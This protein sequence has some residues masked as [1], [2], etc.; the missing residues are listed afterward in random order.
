MSS[1][2]EMDLND[3]AVQAVKHHRDP[4][5]AKERRDDFVPIHVLLNQLLA[6]VEGDADRSAPEG[7]QSYT[8]KEADCVSV[9]WGHAIVKAARV[10]NAFRDA[11]ACAGGKAPHERPAPAEG[12]V[13]AKV[14]HERQRV[15]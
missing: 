10:H 2:F 5:Y 1:E 11:E 3:R 14:P 15:T 8:G 13:A 6:L 4:E 12:A 9:G 7:V